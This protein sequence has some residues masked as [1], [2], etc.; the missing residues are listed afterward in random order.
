MKVAMSEQDG[1]THVKI[2]V[3]HPDAETGYRLLSEALGTS[4]REFLNGT[5][6]SLSMAADRR[7]R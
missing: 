3:D 4:D 1:T 2:E 5:L 7:K 6:K